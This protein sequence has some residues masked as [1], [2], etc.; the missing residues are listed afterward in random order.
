MQAVE[1]SIIL[2]SLSS[3]I[4]GIMY[5]LRKVYECK[6]C[7]ISCNQKVDETAS[8]T[9]KLDIVNAINQITE[10]AN[11]LKAKISP[12]KKNIPSPVVSRR[13]IPVAIF[14]RSADEI[15]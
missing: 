8:D 4:A 1:I 13:P 6:S 7:C 3:L 11:N 14:S 9:G 10:M 12:R 2:I 5:N 15:V